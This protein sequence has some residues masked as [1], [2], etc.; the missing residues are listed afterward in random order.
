MMRSLS[1]T[2]PAGTG[3]PGHDVFLDTIP[4]DQSVAQQRVS[5]L[6][7]VSAV[8]SSDSDVDDNPQRQ[9][10]TERR[11]RKHREGSVTSSDVNALVQAEAG[12]NSDGQHAKNSAPG[13]FGSTRAVTFSLILFLIT[14][15]IAVGVY[16]IVTRTDEVTNKATTIVPSPSDAPSAELTFPPNFYVELNTDSPSDAPSM[17]PEAIAAMDE[18]LLKI[19]DTNDYYD[20]TTPQGYCRNWMLTVDQVQPTVMADGDHAVQQRYILCVLYYSTNSLYFDPYLHECNWTSVSCNSNLAVV[21]YLNGYNLTGTVPSEL[22]YLSQLQMLSLGENNL[23]GTIPPEIMQLPKLAR[24]DLSSNRLTGIFPSASRNDAQQLYPPLEVLYLDD[25]F[26]EGTIPLINTLKR[27]KVQRNRFTGFDENYATLPS[28]TSW[29]M[30]EN[31]ISGTLPQR[32]DAPSLTYIDF[33][34]NSWTGS[35]PESMWNLP[36]IET[37]ALHDS[38]LTGTLPASTVGVRWK[39]LWL[40]SNHFT[41]T[42]PATFGSNWTNLTELLLYNNSLSGTISQ[43]QCNQWANISRLEADCRR[44]NFTCECCTLCPPES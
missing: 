5:N 22:G 32:W 8:A 39:Y 3:A 18:A 25:N 15:A 42:I 6:S 33:A 34:I 26:L 9:S 28:L 21:L 27:I 4:E 2:K 12:T 13:F 16:F 19:T 36:S 23:S 29:K 10:H 41:G 20:E 11:R 44:A 40:H 24:L 1:S 31:S 14:V 35:I 17:N 38:H 7:N 37:L 43:D 30:Y